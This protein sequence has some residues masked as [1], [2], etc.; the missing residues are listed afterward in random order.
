MWVLTVSNILAVNCLMLAIRLAIIFNEK[1]PTDVV[2]AKQF[3]MSILENLHFGSK[4]CMREM[5]FHLKSFRVTGLFLVRFEGNSILS[6]M[7]KLDFS[8]ILS[9]FDGKSILSNYFDLVF[10]Y[11]AIFMK[12]LS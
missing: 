8:G 10:C 4:L 12:Q 6:K 11:Y 7:L 1:S 9:K 5:I 2:T 3:H